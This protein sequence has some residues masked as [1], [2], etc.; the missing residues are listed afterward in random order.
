MKRFA[1]MLWQEEDGVL[2]F[3]WTLLFTLLTFGIIGGLAASRDAVIDELG[4]VAQAMQALD[5]S[6]TIDLPLVFQVDGVTIGGASDSGYLDAITYVDCDRTGG[7]TGQGPQV[8]ED[9]DS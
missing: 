4:D 2:A 5:G 1:V 9:S 6:Y 3:E 7:P 8:V